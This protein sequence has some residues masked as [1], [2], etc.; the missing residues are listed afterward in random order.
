[1]STTEPNSADTT[2]DDVDNDEPQNNP[3]G[4]IL[5]PAN[6]DKPGPDEPGPDEPDAPA[7]AHPA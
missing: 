2:S 7:E 5:T 3:A 6:P 1:M 4:E